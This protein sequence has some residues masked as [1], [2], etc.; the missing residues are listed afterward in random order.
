MALE[1][2]GVLAPVTGLLPLHLVEF[3]CRT[4]SAGPP[5][6]VAW[7]DLDDTPASQSCL[8]GLGHLVCLT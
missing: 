6:R 7:Q 3:L 4:W 1:P 8:V 5:R 2:I